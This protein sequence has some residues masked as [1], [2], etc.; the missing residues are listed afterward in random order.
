MSRAGFLI[1]MVAVL[2][3]GGCAEETTLPVT[4]T[5]YADLVYSDL[6]P[7]QGIT[8][9]VEGLELNGVS[10]PD[11][12]VIVGGLPI[13]GP[14]DQGLFYV[15]RGRGERDGIPVGFV[16]DSVQ[17]ADQETY[18]IG[19][20]SVQPMGALAGAVLLAGTSDN[21]GALIR[22]EGTSLS[23]VSR[24]DGVFL[25]NDVPAHVAYRLIFTAEGYQEQIKDTMPGDDGPVPITVTAGDTT[26]VGLTLMAPLPARKEN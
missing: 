9:W 14:P 13:T 25:I 11:G 7:A 22:V 4:G 20:V 17:V 8:V 19:Q 12:R 3:S 10:G 2:W 6:E 18:F 5:I 23:A 16:V 24:R 26:I 1:L 21:S 15:I